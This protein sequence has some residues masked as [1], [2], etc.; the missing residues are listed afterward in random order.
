MGWSG[1]GQGPVTSQSQ[2][3]GGSVDAVRTAQLVA[4]CTA[5]ATAAVLKAQVSSGEEEGGNFS[6][7]GRL[8]MRL[9][10][11]STRPALVKEC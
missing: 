1:S 3:V 11:C 10:Q 9:G 5:A 6:S 2:S 4:T 7:L 8:R